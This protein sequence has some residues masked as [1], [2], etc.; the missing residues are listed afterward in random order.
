M[1][2]HNNGTVR[3]RSGA[4]KHHPTFWAAA[5]PV[6]KAK[7]KASNALETR[8]VNPM[9]DDELLDDNDGLTTNGDMSAAAMIEANSSEMTEEEL[10]D[11]T[12]AFRKF[13]KSQNGILGIVCTDRL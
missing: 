9:L 3:W 13:R 8:T 12:Y 7:G 4:T 10:A 5:M 2:D 6:S 11:L 1:I